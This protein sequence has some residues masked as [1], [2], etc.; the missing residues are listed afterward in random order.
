MKFTFAQLVALL[1]PSTCQRLER[2]F[3]KKNRLS[4]AEMSQLRTARE[5]I[6]E[7]N[8]ATGRSTDTLRT[9]QSVEPNLLSIRTANSLEPNLLSVYSARSPGVFTKKEGMLTA[10]SPEPNL[11]SVRTANSLE[12][13]LLSVKPAKELTTI[14]N[15]KAQSP[16]KEKH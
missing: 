16:G 6:S 12:P 10:Q 15:L 13:N 1:G 9:A 4:D 7:L 14:S 2:E 5:S 3:V 11:L 8:L